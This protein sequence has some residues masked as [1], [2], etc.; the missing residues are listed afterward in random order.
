MGL[1]QHHLDDDEVRAAM[2]ELWTA[3]LGVLQKEY[4]QDGWPYGKLLTDVGGDVFLKVM[5]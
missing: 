4:P 1:N 5:P 3:E 2:V